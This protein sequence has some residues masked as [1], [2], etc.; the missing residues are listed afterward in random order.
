MSEEAK[1]FT[2]SIKASKE[3]REKKLKELRER[4]A[5]RES[6]ETSNKNPFPTA[7]REETQSLFPFP[8]EKISIDSTNAD[9]FVSQKPM[10][11]IKQ[12]VNNILVPPK[13]KAISYEREIQAEIYSDSEDEEDYSKV[14]EENDPRVRKMSLHQEK[15][16]IIEELQK[17]TESLPKELDPDE[18]EQI[19]ASQEFSDFLEKSSKLMT[20]S[21]EEEFDIMQNFI[22][23]SKT[24]ENNDQKGKIKIVQFLQFTDEERC[25]SA[26]EWSPSY[27]DLV[28]AA[29]TRAEVETFGLPYGVINLWSI[30]NAKNPKH[31]LYC[32]SSVTQSQFYPN[33]PN[34]IIG[35]TYSGQILL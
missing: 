22:L 7:R 10:L 19:V 16:E 5:K 31:T 23:S 30:E 25:I 28:L 15:P 18:L 14:T 34:T 1:K 2:D 8:T 4:K 21:L 26:L 29:Y 3:E 33:D 9:S 11:A 24:D 12:N 6:I 27:E 35:G 20:Q 32:Q 17:V 13:A